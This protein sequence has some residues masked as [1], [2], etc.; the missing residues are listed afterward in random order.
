M[1]AGINGQGDEREASDA[2]TWADGGGLVG[3]ERVGWGGTERGRRVRHD[4]DAP[5]GHVVSDDNDMQ[6]EA[7]RPAID[8]DL[9]ARR[10]DDNIAAAIH[11]EHAEPVHDLYDDP[12]HHYE[13]DG[14]AGIDDDRDADHDHDPAAR[15]DYDHPAA[16][17]F[18]DTAAGHDH[19]VP[20]SVDVYDWSAG[21]HD[22]DPARFHDNLATRLDD[23]DPGHDD[24]DAEHRQQH[25][26]ARRGGRRIIAARDGVLWDLGPAGTPPTPRRIADDDWALDATVA[27]RDQLRAEYIRKRGALDWHHRWIVRK[28]LA[29]ADIAIAV[30]KALRRFG[31]FD[32]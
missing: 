11:D 18:L 4:H 2:G 15:Y 25:G 13:H 16:R 14:L 1:Q 22:F 23:H 6:D 8:D 9:G 5:G 19:D 12:A 26:S 7:D 10:D 31:E 21:E 3:D 20:A 32:A 30:R 27:R 29:V 24:D 17:H 28:E